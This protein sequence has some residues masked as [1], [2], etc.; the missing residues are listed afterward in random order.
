MPMLDLQVTDVREETPTIRS[1]KLGLEGKSFPFKPGQYCLIQLPAGDEPEDRPLSIV[2]SPSRTDMLQFAT[3]RSD[4]AFKKSFFALRPGD[5]VTVNGP[6]GRFV[7]DEAFPQTVLLSGG[8]GITPLMSMMA[9]ATDRQITNPMV[10]LFGNR[11]PQ[12]IPFRGE[13]DRIADQNPHCTVVHAVSSVDGDP[14]SWKGHVGRIDEGLIRSRVPDQGQPQFYLC[15]PPGMVSG[16]RAVLDRMSIPKE[17][18]HVEN[19]EGY[20]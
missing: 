3:R 10:L 1:I 15:G 20:D 17:S 19:F 16:L 11:S 13:L 8:I 4:S 2:S 9:Y 5:S 18:I 12:E 6:F 14:A 7:Y